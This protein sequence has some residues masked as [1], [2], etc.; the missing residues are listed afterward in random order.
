MRTNP[1]IVFVHQ[2][3]VGNPNPCEYVSNR[4]GWPVGTYSVSKYNSKY[5]VIKHMFLLINNRRK[6]Y[7]LIL[8][9]IFVNIFQHHTPLT[10]HPAELYVSSDTTAQIVRN[11][12]QWRRG[13]ASIK[14]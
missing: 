3:F 12:H 10:P 8:K 13:A 11:L 6:S 2:V 14:V 9:F 4:L 5:F 1:V 7:F